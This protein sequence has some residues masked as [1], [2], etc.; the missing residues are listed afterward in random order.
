MIFPPENIAVDTDA[1]LNIHVLHT[2][3]YL[4]KYK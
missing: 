1:P 3:N 4:N 2:V